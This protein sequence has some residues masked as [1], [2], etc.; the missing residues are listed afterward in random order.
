M[1][2]KK[3]EPAQPDKRLLALSVTGCSLPLR[4]EVLMAMSTKM[5]VFWLVPVQCSLL[6]FQKF[7]LF[8]AS[9]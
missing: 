8:P 2:F 3:L 7:L 1:L 5:A 4:L 6:T 9:R